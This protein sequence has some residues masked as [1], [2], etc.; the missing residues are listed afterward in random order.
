MQIR[1]KG[2]ARVDSEVGGRDPP[3]R[4]LPRALYNIICKARYKVTHETFQALAFG[5]TLPSRI[6]FLKGHDQQ[7]ERL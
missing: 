7:A 2:A 6:C 4:A 1:L 5:R 3:S